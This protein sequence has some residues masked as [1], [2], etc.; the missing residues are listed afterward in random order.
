[1][2][3]NNKK[4]VVSAVKKAVISS[5]VSLQVYAG[6]ECGREAAV[7]AIDSIFNDE[8]ADVVLLIDSE[9]A[10]SSV[11]REVFKLYILC[12]CYICFK[13]LFQVI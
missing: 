6:H 2:E 8:N 3:E 7:Q 4:I 11:I 5:V 1:M 9:N 10:F 12:F 13:F